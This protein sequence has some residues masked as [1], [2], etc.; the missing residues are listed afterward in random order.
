MIAVVDLPAI[1]PL[2]GSPGLST[3]AGASFFPRDE[4]LRPVRLETVH[5]P[6]HARQA[7][8]IDDD[9]QIFADR[10]QCFSRSRD[11][12]VTGHYRDTITGRGRA[13]L[14]HAREVSEGV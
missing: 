3:L 6:A 12:E 7:R 13:N 14:W 4:P 1:T 8:G 9:D 2:V 5:R 11:L 10:R